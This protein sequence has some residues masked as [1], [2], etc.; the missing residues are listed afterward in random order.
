[1]LLLL[2]A[3]SMGSKKTNITEARYKT[4]MRMSS[5][6]GKEL[7]ARI[8]KKNCASL[9]PCTKTLLNH[10]KRAQYV[11]RMWK[12]ADE[13]NPTGEVSPTDYG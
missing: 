8:K 6:K 12:R 13:T 11:A 9:L 1:M 5:G 4:F 3:N 2:S 10:I 7:L